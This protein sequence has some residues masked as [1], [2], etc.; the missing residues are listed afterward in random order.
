MALGLPE[1]HDHDKV[2][3]ADFVALAVF[4]AAFLVW[5]LAR[6][7]TDSRPPV[8][9][10]ATRAPPSSPRSRVNNARSL[11]LAT[12]SCSVQNACPVTA[13]GSTVAA[14]MSADSRGK[15]LRTSSVPAATCSPAIAR[16]AWAGS[17]TPRARARSA[18]RPSSRSP[19]M[20]LS[21]NASP[22]SGRA[23][24]RSIVPPGL[25]S[26]EARSDLLRPS[27]PAWCDDNHGGARLRGPAGLPYG[28][29]QVPPVER[30]AGR[31]GRPDRRAAPA[32][33]G[34]EGPRRPALGDH[35]RDRGVPAPAAPQ[36]R[37]AGQPRPGGRARQPEQGRHRRQG[38]A[39]AADPD[40]RA[41]DRAPHTTASGRAAPARAVAAPS[42]WLGSLRRGAPAELI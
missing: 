11:V 27:L 34:G 23:R 39:G 37:R 3:A 2:W 5:R 1:R 24:R 7:G 12:L 28:A 8:S 19:K 16:V 33:P 20:P 30:A 35:R 25:G 31:G 22:S 13:S 36:H 32:A 26:W 40:R 14:R 42:R 4:F 9:A 6:C 10:T 29:A 18:R 21:M 15:R 17:L 41:G 38:G